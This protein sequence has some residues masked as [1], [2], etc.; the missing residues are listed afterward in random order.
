[1]KASRNGFKLKLN[2][3]SELSFEASALFQESRRYCVSVF[4]KSS[5]GSRFS[6]SRLDVEALEATDGLMVE[7]AA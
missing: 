2:P 1:M 5:S 6:S 3:M 4:E 7:P